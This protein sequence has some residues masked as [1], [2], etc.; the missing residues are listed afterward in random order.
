MT[1]EPTA[2]LSALIDIEDVRAA[3][4]RVMPVAYR[5]FVNNV[6]MD[7]TLRGDPRLSRPPV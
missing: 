5:D 1:N 3:A 6:G 4:E 7:E 2:D